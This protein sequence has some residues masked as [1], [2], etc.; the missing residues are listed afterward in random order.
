MSLCREHFLIC[1]GYIPPPMLDKVDKKRE[2]DLKAYKFYLKRVENE[3]ANNM[4]TFKDF[5]R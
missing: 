5:R 3:K 2:E 4:S 1:S